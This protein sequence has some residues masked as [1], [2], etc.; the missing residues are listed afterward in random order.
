MPRKN[1]PRKNM[2]NFSFLLLFLKREQNST[3]RFAIK[4]TQWNLPRKKCWPLDL[5]P[6]KTLFMGVGK[7]R[8]N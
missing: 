1:M 2:P 6:C 7:E 4:R 3:T 8:T 5:A